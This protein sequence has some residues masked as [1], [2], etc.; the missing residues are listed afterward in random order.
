MV[1]HARVDLSGKLDKAGW[2]LVLTGLPG[3]VKRINRNAVPAKARTRVER[4]KSKW[5]RLRRLNHLP[6]VDTHR[7]VHDL[8]LIH[9]RNVYRTKDIFCGLYRFGS[10]CR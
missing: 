3:E 4:H 5:L 8:E 10:C 1:R 2:H 6:D 7:C 9:E